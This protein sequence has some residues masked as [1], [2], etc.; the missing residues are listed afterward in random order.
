[1]TTMPADGVRP[2]HDHTPDAGRPGAAAQHSRRQLLRWAAI[3][4][5]A[6][7]ASELLAACGSGSAASGGQRQAAAGSLR[8]LVADAPQLS[9]LGAQSLLP[10]GRSRFAFGLAGPTNALV[11]GAN[12]QVW[13]AKDQ[14]SRALGPFP[15]RWL[16]LTGYQQT[17]DRSPRSQLNGFYLAEVDLPQPGTWQ[18]AAIVEVASQRAAGQGAIKASRQVP[19]PVGSKALSGPTP[20]ATSPSGLARICTRTPVCPMHT[21]SLDQALRSGKPTVL[22]FATP[23]LCSSRMCGPV[24]DEQIL[25]FRKLGERANFIHVEIYPQ[26][27]L[28]KPAPLYTAWKLPTEP[29]MFVIDRDGVIRARLGEGPTVA[30]EIEAAVRPLLA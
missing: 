29:W 11:E 13:L 24:V 16:K 9:I 14:T 20:V 4:A 21:I 2:R 30:A 17:H 18:A 23:L 6:L 19:A 3:A 5:G 22:S 1:M 27:D 25:A 7:G 15:A 10:A 8:A 28:N 26:R 12:P